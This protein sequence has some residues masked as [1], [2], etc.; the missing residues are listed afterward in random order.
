MH[1][2]E[3]QDIHKKT[4][5]DFELLPVSFCVEQFQK[6]AI[7]GESGSGK[8]TLVKII[9]GLAQPDG[10]QVLF[11]GVRVKGP[12]EKL[13]MATPG[14]AYLSQHFELKE[15]YWVEDIL[16]YS[17]QLTEASSRELFDICRISHLLRRKTHQV[18]GGEKQRIAL[19]RLLVNTPRLL[20][21]DEPYSNL[22][23]ITKSI[24]K[25]VIRDVSEQL[26]ITCML[27]SHDPLD[28]LPWA[29]EVIVMKGGQ[30]MQKAAPEVIY[31]EPVNEY[32]AGIFGKYNLLPPALV[33]ALGG[34]AKA[35]TFV[36][37]E[38][39]QVVEK[40]GVKGMV[41]AVHFVGY[42]YDV[43]VQ[44]DDMLLSVR[45]GG[46]GFKTGNTVKVAW[47]G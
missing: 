20:I 1:F 35:A 18:S 32:V 27:V 9:G 28:I 19:A 2:L 15:N 23:L 22:D 47:R 6:L 41:K 11:E 30:I 21:L 24:L 3:I 8:S 45:A 7:A 13:M 10:G 5:S 39:L 42:G 4:G 40:G 33:K 36:R 17:N 37:P 26:K 14:M 29:D 38:Q 34:K 46:N 12:E 43:Q 16:N 25:D 31:R 44:V